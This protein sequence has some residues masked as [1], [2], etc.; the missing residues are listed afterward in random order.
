MTGPTRRCNSCGNR[1][2]LTPDH[3]WRCASD[4]FGFQT[5]CKR[6]Q[7]AARTRSMRT[8]TRES[9][10]RR[11]KHCHTCEGMPWRRPRVGK[12]RCNGVYAAEPAM[13]IEEAMAAP[14]KYHREV[15]L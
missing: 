9:I 6:C 13:T 11:G 8:S 5:A 15:A 4:V 10:S 12:C 2:P 7:T 1:F 14:R 3:F